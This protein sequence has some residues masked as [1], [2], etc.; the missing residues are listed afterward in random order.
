MFIWFHKHRYA[1]TCISFMPKNKL[2]MMENSI[3]HAMFCK[4]NVKMYCILLNY[5]YI[6]IKVIYIFTSH[7]L[8]YNHS[9]RSGNSNHH[10]FYHWINVLI[11]QWKMNCC[12][13]YWSLLVGV[14]LDLYLCRKLV[15]EILNSIRKINLKMVWRIT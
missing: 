10:R 1:L 11:G 7:S 4:W 14:I 15:I 13:L 6:F 5:S 8:R 3:S 2:L 9:L 12:Y